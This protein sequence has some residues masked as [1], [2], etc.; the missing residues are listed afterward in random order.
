MSGLKG[1]HRLHDDQGRQIVQVSFPASYRTYAY[2]A[3][4]GVTLAVGDVVRVPPNDFNPEGSKARVRRLG[5]EYA[6]EL[7]Q[8]VCKV[9]KEVRLN[10]RKIPAYRQDSTDFQDEIDYG[11]PG[12]GEAHG[13]N[14]TEHDPGPLDCGDR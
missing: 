2:A 8:L 11:V 3:P 9:D 14:A 10:V 6:G 4:D 1:P 5:S 13:D 12:V 7:T